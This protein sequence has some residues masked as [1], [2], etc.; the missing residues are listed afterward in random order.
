MECHVILQLKKKK[1]KAH[2]QKKKEEEEE[3]VVVMGTNVPALWEKQQNAR[4]NA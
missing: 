2:I 1:K 4:I 3:L